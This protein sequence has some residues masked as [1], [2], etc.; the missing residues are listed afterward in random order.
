MLSE[1]ARRFK[2][3][4]YRLHGAFP[5]VLWSGG[6]RRDRVIK[7]A[8]IATLGLLALAAP[9]LAFEVTER[10]LQISFNHA[11]KDYVRNDVLV[12][13][14]PKNACYDWHQRFKETS[15]PIAVTEWLTLPAAIDWGNLATNPNDGIEIQDNGTGAKS[16]LSLVT[17]DTGWVTHGWCAAEGDP[18]GR[19][20][21][22]IM[23]GDKQLAAF[24]FSV[25]DPSEYNFPAA[26][27]EPGAPRSGTRV[28]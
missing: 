5:L 20:V 14:L 22:E 27:R 21:L 19:H 2:T 7:A 26:P 28:W 3:G 16:T 4:P 23:A 6:F 15:T 10:Q 24:G 9:V 12:P 13:L 11:G 25:I 17:D 8:A 18:L 1:P